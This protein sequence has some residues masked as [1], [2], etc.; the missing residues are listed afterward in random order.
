MWILP[1]L[2]TITLVG[3]PDL[4][5]LGGTSYERVARPILQKLGRKLVIGHKGAKAQRE[6][7]TKSEILSRLSVFV[8]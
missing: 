6:R 2:F 4:L 8:T 5:D 1:L 7:R 3:I